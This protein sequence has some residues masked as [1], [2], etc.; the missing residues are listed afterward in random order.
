MCEKEVIATAV[1]EALGGKYEKKNGV[2]YSG[3]DVLVWTFGH[4]L[5]L[6]DPERYNEKYKSWKLEDLPIYFEPWEN[7]VSPEKRDR[8]KQIG[9]FLKNAD[10]VVNCGDVDE[11]GQLL[12]DE[13]LRYFN[14]KGS[15]KRLDTADTSVKAV[16][17]NLKQMKDNRDCESAGWSAYARQVSDMTFGIN[18]TRFFSK[19]YNAK[20][21]VGRVQT[22]TL[23]LVIKRDEAIEGHKKVYYYTMS[24][25]VS[26]Q[27]KKIL[28]SF[29]PQKD[30]N[31]LTDGKFLS[32]SFLKNLGTS[33]TGSTIKCTVK[34][35][36]VNES[37]PLP[38]NLNKLNLY[39]GKKWGYK[40]D[41]I[42][43]I[44]QDLRDKYSA[45]TYNRSDC[46]YLS[47]EH[48]KEAPGTV[49]A[50][51]KNKGIDNIFDTK[52][53][54]KCFND[55]YISAHFAIIPTAQAVDIS[56][57]TR[58]EKNVYEAISNFYLAQFLPPCT[59]EKLKVSAP[60]FYNGKEVGTLN[61]TFTKIVSAGWRAFLQDVE[62]ED[63]A[64]TAV[65]EAFS[66]ADG[67]YDGIVDK[68][69]YE[70]KETKPPKRYT[71]V[72]LC[73]D[74]T[75]ISKYVD[76]PDIKRLLL[77]KDKEKKG[78]NG[79][80]GT[81]ATRDTIIN[82]LIKVGF[83]EEKSEGKNNDVLI[84]T[85]KGRMFYKLLPDNIK[86][87]D[88]TALWWV[89]QEDIRL[90]KADYTNLTHDVLDTIKNVMDTYQ[91]KEEDL[92]SF[93]TNKAKAVC[94]CPAC[95]SDIVKGKFGLYCTGKCGFRLTSVFGRPVTES[96]YI[97]LCNGKKTKITGIKKKNSTDTFDAYA[98]PDGIE[99]YSYD[100]DGKHYEGKQLKINMVFK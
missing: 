21:P 69:T 100:K 92:A 5:T 14:F 72:T 80:I 61:R 71:Q 16:Q 54:S 93:A 78:E 19:K 24:A 63:K 94:R 43:K 52:I 6:K 33:I 18:F 23:G 42:M 47:S 66:I 39:C 46:Q 58:D 85:K 7:D 75:K 13:V 67:K 56:K 74:M 31:E 2:I 34:R 28:L 62:D 65:S 8:V 36:K 35:E 48:F 29:T 55:E 98:V 82:K 15:V 70:K 27:D 9:E 89:V 87:A 22:P 84:S 96:Q 77:E 51:C 91:V 81:S 25:G 10:E 40:P 30:L 83:L 95:G 97:S 17:K 38:F 50:V 49:E 37:A 11:E 26:V 1:A 41:K 76:D 32:D 44:T 59:K 12:V 99:S 68:C 60:V 3:N 86:K 73:D 57:F 53:K 88:T 4:C 45:I 79:S 64:D 20:L 90:G